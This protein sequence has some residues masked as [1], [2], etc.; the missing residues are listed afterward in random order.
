MTEMQSA[1]ADLELENLKKLASQSLKK[2]NRL[3]TTTMSSN[4]KTPKQPSIANQM[5]NDNLNTHSKN[6]L[7]TSVSPTKN[8]VSEIQADQSKNASPL[9]SP[10]GMEIFINLIEQ[11]KEEVLEK[12]DILNE[13]IDKKDGVVIEM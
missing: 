1:N 2:S 10:G 6:N 9:K 3:S 13:K 8:G 5:E 7:N 11:A 12:V 4:S